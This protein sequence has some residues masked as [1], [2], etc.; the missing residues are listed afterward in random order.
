[1]KVFQR[2]AAS[3]TVVKSAANLFGNQMAILPP[4]PL[5]R[6]LLRAHRKLPKEQRTLGDEYIKA[7]F[8]AHKSVEN[9]V[10]I[11]GF[12][13]EWQMYAQ[14]IEGNSWRDGRMDKSKVDKMSDDQITQMYELMQAIRNRELEENDAEHTPPPPPE[15]KN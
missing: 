7:E 12:L 14:T 9:P 2:L 3:A 6:R 8:R 10:Q 13:S 4:I 5:Y 11:I 1:M 15:P